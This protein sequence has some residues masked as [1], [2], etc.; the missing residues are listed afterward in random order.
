M[1]EGGVF[2]ILFALALA[3]NLFVR[4][5]HEGSQLYRFISLV[6]LSSSYFALGFFFSQIRLWLNQ[7][8]RIVS[9]IVLIVV[10]VL[11]SE[12]ELK[13]GML[14]LN[15]WNLYTF[16]F[17]YVMSF[18]GIV[19]VFALS[20]CIDRS[21]LKCFFDFLGR[22]TMPILVWHFLS[23]KIVSFLIVL[24][25]GFPID[26]LSDFPTVKTNNSWQWIAYTFVGMVVPLFISKAKR[27]MN[28]KIG[29]ITFTNQ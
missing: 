10:A 6:L 16:L 14:N 18:V 15:E 5:Y 3:T 1:A 25:Y 8:V 22:N 7:Y 27:M 29:M 21:R 28:K 13:L 24:I 2:L 17:V 19:W 20:A 26:S 4:E 9:F 11:V 12:W 23:F